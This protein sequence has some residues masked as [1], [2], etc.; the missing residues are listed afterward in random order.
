MKPERT[1]AAI[2]D[3]A[4]DE[5]V[6]ER[7][8]EMVWAPREEERTPLVDFEDLAGWQVHMFSGAEAEFRR[9]REQQMWGQFVGKL[10]Y[11]GTSQD[12]RVVILPAQPVPITKPFD[13]VNFWVYGNNWGWS[14]DPSTPQVALA[15]LVADAR[16]VEHRIELTR[17]RWKEW[18]LVHRRIPKDLLE[19]MAPPWSLSGIEI[20]GC[21]PARPGNVEPRTL[22]FDSLYFYREQLKPLRFE[23]RPARNLELLPGQS[24]GLNGTAP[25]RLRFPTREQTILPSNFEKRFQTSVTQPEPGLFRFRYR[26]YS[27]HFSKEGVA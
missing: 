19:K 13:C 6:G 24:Q 25:G 26:L 5:S 22:F 23:P 7:P 1:A 10:T 3:V 17:I 11:K 14:S 8:Y 9:T 18:W 2:N 21:S 12:S 20:A 15:V 16:G 4:A 27:G